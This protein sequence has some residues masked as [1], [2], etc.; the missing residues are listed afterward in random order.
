MVN[1]KLKNRRQGIL[2]G[3][4]NI[5][6]YL[7][8]GWSK[9]GARPLADFKP[10]NIL[11]L[12]LDEIGDVLLSTPA[13]RLLRQLYPGAKIIVAVRRPGYEILAGNPNIDQLLLVDLPRF[14]AETA[15]MPADLKKIKQALPVIKSKLPGMIDLGI[16]LRAD[17]RTIY[18][19]K[20]LG[21]KQRISQSIRGG[22]FWLTQIAPYL[23][24]QHEV[25]RKI[26]II[27]YLR[28]AA[29]LPSN[30][31][32]EIAV[33]TD[34]KRQAGEILA[35]N[36]VKMADKYTVFHP[37]AGWKPKE[38]PA[39]RFVQI[40]MYLGTDYHQKVVII[41]SAAE[42]EA[43]EKITRAAGGSTVN[44]AGWADLKTMAAIIAG[45]KLF[46]GNDSGPMHIACAVQTPVIAL[47]G[48]NTP[49][50]Y[51][52]WQ[53]KNIT[54]YHPVECSPC[55]Q[56][57]CSRRPRCMEII[58]VDEVKEAIGRILVK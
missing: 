43:A 39:D 19:L 38:W 37:F 3:L 7:I 31:R 57:S 56:T 8:W 53:N 22:G 1:Y 46:I 54:I 29:S 24:L 28:P 5:A 50:R 4:V 55:P 12:Q 20:K 47:F 33:N 35:Q 48:Q 17:L 15:K 14:S 10:K 42:R 40:A 21:A 6:G 25:E 36:G 11:V 51:G 34:N 45:A 9:I 27:H 16:D 49:R 32:L 18:L 41:G 23:G 2:L 30:L 52:P 13:L 44:L 58:S 26:G